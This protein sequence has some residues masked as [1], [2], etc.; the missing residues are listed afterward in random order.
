MSERDASSWDFDESSLDISSVVK[1]ARYKE[2][3]EREQKKRLE[4]E[5]KQQGKT[6]EAVKISM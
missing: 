5:G 6:F 3:L 1:E 2:R 4:R